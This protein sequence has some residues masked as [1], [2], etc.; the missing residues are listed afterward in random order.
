MITA[1]Q[2]KKI[3]PNCKEPA[4]WAQVISE[5]VPS[6]FN[7]KELAKFIAQCGHESMHFNVLEENL[8][9]SADRLMVIFPKYFRNRDVNMYHRKPELIANV[10]YANRIGNGDITSG[11]G[12]KFRGRGIIQLTG[13]ANYA[14]CSQALFGDKEVLLNNPDLVLEPNVAMK[15]AF[16]FWT[17]NGLVG[18]DN[19]V[20]LT[21]RINGG[22]HGLEDRTNICKVATEVLCA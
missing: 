22:T 2:L 3:L 12:Y 14:A 21:K 9:Y 15:S 20:T 16:W 8:N 17:S 11:D 7:S 6:N 10:V 1:E 18:I 13:R 4:K 19:F 5:T